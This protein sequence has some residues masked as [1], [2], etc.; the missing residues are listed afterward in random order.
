MKPYLLF[1]FS[2]SAFTITFLFLPVLIKLLTQW[3][4]YDSPGKHKIHMQFTPSMGGICILLGAA[5]AQI[6]GMPLAEW[7][8]FK[9]FYICIALMFITG[10]RDDILTLNPRQKLIG[11]LLPVIILVVFGDTV[12]WSFYGIGGSAIT[13]PEL[14]GWTISIFTI[15]ILTNA[16]NLIDGLD[17]LAGTVGLIS[18]LCFGTWFYLMSEPR[19]TL[20]SF[21]FAGAVAAFLYY[22]W[23][24]S[25]IFMGDTGALVLGVLLSFLTIQFINANFALPAGHPFKFSASIGTALMIMIIPVFDTLRVIVLR[26][27]K[28]QSPFKADKNHLH[29]QFLKMGFSHSKSVIIIAA[30]H[31][32]FVVLAVV[33]K[34]STDSLILPLVILACLVINVTIRVTQKRYER[35]GGKSF[36]T[37]K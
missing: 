36:I 17:G 11:Q 21:S 12:L 5:F 3:R 15:V 35:N 16:Y 24:P 27:R 2:A 29:H 19:L 23:E 30:I 28:F 26:L 33:L 14:A 32:F 34:N 9:Y 31:L 25:R 20:I 22:N 37:E 13:F 8:N 7:G 6:I 1:I 4:V 10:L 18:L